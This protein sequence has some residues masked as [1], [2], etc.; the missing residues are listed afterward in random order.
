MRILI[1]LS[2][3][4]MAFGGLALAFMGYQGTDRAIKSS[5]TALVGGP[6]TLTS[7]QGDVV[8]DQ[9]FKGRMMLIYFGFTFC[10]DVCPTGLQEMA[11]A[12]DHLE[13]KVGA[14]K[15]GAIQPLFIT[16]DP[17]RDTVAQ[18]QNYVPYFHSRLIGLTG[19]EDQVAAVLKAYRVYAKK[20]PLEAGSDPDDYL[21]DHTSL[22]Y[23]MDGDGNYLTHF[24]DRTPADDMATKIAGY[25]D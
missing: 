18:L 9:D 12:V 24:P 8:T 19:T 22:F 21:M 10:P 20:A 7:H 5:G 1:I 17:A 13:A 15:A 16:V 4:V 2:F 3:A 6:F 25:L 23:L 14:E 11:R